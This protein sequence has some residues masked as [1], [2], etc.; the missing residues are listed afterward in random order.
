MTDQIQKYY[1]MAR[2]AIKEGA[3][4]Q[5]TTEM[6]IYVGCEYGKSMDI[7]I[8]VYCENSNKEAV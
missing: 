3:T 1:D 4:L 8:D 5:T 6:L 2:I 7:A